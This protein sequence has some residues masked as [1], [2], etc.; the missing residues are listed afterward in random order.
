MVAR[1]TS[2][3]WRRG[4]RVRAAQPTLVSL[5][6]LDFSLLGNVHVSYRPGGTRLFSYS[7]SNLAAFEYV[8]LSTAFTLNSYVAYE[9]RY[10]DSVKKLHFECN[11]FCSDLPDFLNLWVKIVFL[12]M[13]FLRPYNNRNI[14]R[15]GKI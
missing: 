11:L 6:S 5:S 12:L 3:Q 1:W 7:P 13:L 15:E 14:F 4:S 10:S 9:E 2:G 8:G